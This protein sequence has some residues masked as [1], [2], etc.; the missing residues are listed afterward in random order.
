MGDFSKADRH[1][2]NLLKKVTVNKNI[3]V[4][5]YADTGH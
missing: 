2:Q 3:V 4:K 1:V 5:L